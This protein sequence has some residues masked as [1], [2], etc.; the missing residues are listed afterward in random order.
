M[1]VVSI[2][3]E[4][5]FINKG[6]C[7]FLSTQAME[8]AESMDVENSQEKH[9]KRPPPPSL[10]PLTDTIVFQQL[11]IESYVGEPMQGLQ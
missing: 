2:K 6:W 3:F 5:Y 4:V 9:W 10:N 8:E 1:L 7:V 11:D